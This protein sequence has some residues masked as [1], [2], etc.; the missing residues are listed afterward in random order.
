MPDFYFAI[1]AT[2]AGLTNVEVTITDAPNLIPDGLI[3]LLGPV[4]RRT[5]DSA[6]QRNGAIDVPLRFDQMRL[7]DLDTL[8]TTYWTNYTTASVSGFVSWLD[9][10]ARGGVN[11]YS[12]FSCELERPIVG[13]NFQLHDG[14]WAVGPVEIP[15]LNLVHQ[16]NT[17]DS[18]TTI[19][20][21]ER[22]NESDTTAGNVTLTLPAAA[23]YNPNT[24]VSFVK[25]VAANSLI[26]D[27]D[28]VEEID[29]ATTKTITA[30]SR[31]NIVSDGVSAWTS[32]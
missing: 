19:T 27:G 12:P 16:V 25:T 30:V 21:S 10:T 11:N 4:R 28:G 32:I 1:G 15:A 13:E 29:S 23:S 2:L 20:T 8:I 9:E 18:T 6:I 26:L 17:E 5:L 3:P 7:S 22:Y 31:T 14:I 24:V